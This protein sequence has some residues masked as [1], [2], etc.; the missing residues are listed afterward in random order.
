MKLLKTKTR[1][2]QL[3]EVQ[4]HEA[5]LGDRNLTSMHWQNKGT[6]I[7]YFEC[8]IHLYYPLEKFGIGPGQIQ[9]T[10][11]E[12]RVVVCKPGEMVTLPHQYYRMMTRDGSPVKMSRVRGIEH[13]D[14][15]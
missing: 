1:V 8:I 11:T 2:H 3:G 10:P 5:P 6:N 14:P 4:A 9:P 13:L 7:C 15:I 12:W